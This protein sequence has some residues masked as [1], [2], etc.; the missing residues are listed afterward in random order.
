MDPQDFIILKLPQ[1]VHGTIQIH[2]KTTKQHKTT[3]YPINMVSKFIKTRW[4]IVE[5]HCHFCKKEWNTI[6]WHAELKY[7]MPYSQRKEM[8]S[9]CI[10]IDTI[11]TQQQQQ[12]QQQPLALSLKKLFKNMQLWENNNTR[13]T[14]TQKDKQQPKD[15]LSPCPKRSHFQNLQLFCPCHALELKT[16]Q[17][18]CSS[19]H[20]LQ[21]Q[22]DCF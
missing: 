19:S 2:N 15:T 7:K 10:S 18:V 6:C 21:Y 22:V 13:H 17:N 9:L 5:Y 8:S 11:S 20:T 3:T 12:Q 1:H 16:T 14:H 4:I